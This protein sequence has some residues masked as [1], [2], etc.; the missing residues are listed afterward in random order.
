MKLSKLELIEHLGL[1]EYERGRLYSGLKEGIYNHPFVAFCASGVASDEMKVCKSTI[2]W[3]KSS[4]RFCTQDSDPMNDS[5]YK[6]SKTI[7]KL[8]ESDSEYDTFV[9]GYVDID[10]SEFHSS[11]VINRNDYDDSLMTKVIDSVRERAIL[12]YSSSKIL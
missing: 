12:L 2:N 7:S 5:Q 8:Q 11:I 9:F 1:D 6:V 4:R 10:T 3:I